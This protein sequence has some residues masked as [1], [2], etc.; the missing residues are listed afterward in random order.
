MVGTRQSSL[1]KA[2]HWLDTYNTLCNDLV[3]NGSRKKRLEGKKE[4][5]GDREKEVETGDR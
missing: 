2:M 1:T 4:G 5:K 3:L